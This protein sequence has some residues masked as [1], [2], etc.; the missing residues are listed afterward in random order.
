VDLALVNIALPS[1]RGTLGF[2][3]TS[4]SWAVAAALT[5]SD[6]G[7]VTGLLALNLWDP[8]VGLA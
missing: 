2:S 3:T 1:I 5:V 7:T 8:H 6:M 4:L